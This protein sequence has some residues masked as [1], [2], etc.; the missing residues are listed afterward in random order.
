M[1]FVGSMITLSTNANSGNMKLET[2]KRKGQC[3][4]PGCLNR[5]TARHHKGSERMWLRHFGHKRRT[6]RFK[7]FVERY[8][9][10]LPSDCVE[11]CNE[12]HEEI[13]SIYIGIIQ[14]WMRNK[15][16][17]PLWSYTWKEAEEMM[18]ELR[19]VCEKWLTAKTPG[20]PARRPSPR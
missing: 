13:H 9:S 7:T 1:T 11:I 5:Y 19:K 20:L 14:V 10:F 12:H 4:K 2:S 16:S 3:S 17:K 18:A 6:A 8:E 15:K